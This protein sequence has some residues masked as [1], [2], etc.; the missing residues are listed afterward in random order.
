MKEGNG[1]EKVHL[2]EVVVSKRWASPKYGRK[3]KLRPILDV[4]KT[5]RPN[6]QKRYKL[7]HRANLVNCSNR[8]MDTLC[9]FCGN[10]G[11]GV[12][13]CPNMPMTPQVPA[14]MQPT[15]RYQP[16]QQSQPTMFVMVPTTMAQQMIQ[17]RSLMHN[18]QM[19]MQP[20]QSMMRPMPSIGQQWPTTTNQHAMMANNPPMTYHAP[21]SQSIL[22]QSMPMNNAVPCSSQMQ[23]I[24]A[25]PAPNQEPREQQKS[26][27]TM[28]ETPP[29]PAV[30]LKKETGEGDARA[31]LSAKRSLHTYNTPTPSNEHWRVKRSKERKAKQR[32]RRL[33][34]N[35][36]KD[37]EPRVQEMRGHSKY[38]N[39]SNDRRASI[40]EASTSDGR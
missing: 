12:M 20:I 34:G 37:N 14:V 21:M 19:V 22:L 7:R 38:V 28:S 9:A 25:W 18:E 27:Q 35:K 39:T 40:Q 6:A 2:R 26:M 1:S 4:E 16:V 10:V 24:Q 11:H 5:D 23:P 3:R 30:I 8:E 32:E 17:Q 33:L 29:S 36:K 31:V 15:V 13:Q